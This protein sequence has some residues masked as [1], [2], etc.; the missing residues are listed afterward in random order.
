[1]DYISVE[2]QK[3]LSQRY[4]VT[5]V[6]VIA[7]GISLLIQL[8]IARFIKPGEPTPGSETWM[9]PIYSAAIVLGISVVALRR[10]MMS[11]LVMGPAAL[12][13]VESVLRTLQTMTMI[14]CSLAEIVVIGGL[15]FYFLTGDYQYSWRLGIVGLFLLV[16]SF[17]RR[18]EWERLVAATANPQTGS[19]AHTAKPI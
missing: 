1:M 2:H 9:Q 7:Y 4:R 5:S 10:I 17:P 18:S 3:A 6:I 13:G 14:C 15:I 16:Y 12:R 11:K 8:L 19:A